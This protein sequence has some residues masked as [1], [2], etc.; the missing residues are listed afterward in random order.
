MPVPCAS[1]ASTSAGDSP[2]LASARPITRAGDGPFGAVSPLDAPSWLIALPA[3]PRAP[4][5]RP[6]RVR[7]PLHHEHPGTLG[8]A[9]AVRGL[10]ERLA[11]AVG[12][13]PRCRS[14]SGTC[15]GWPS[16][17]RR[18]RAPGALA[19]AQRRTARCSA[20]SDDEQAVS[21]VTAGPSTRR[22]TRRARTPRSGRTGAKVAG[23]PVRSSVS[24]P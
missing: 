17:S 6:H 14:N 7:E 4:G 20:T 10:G 1:T 18:R 15:P 3:P 23:H 12:G 21:T 8:P 16:R 2:A 19:P 22:C 11:P 9:G 13:S 5:A 24:P